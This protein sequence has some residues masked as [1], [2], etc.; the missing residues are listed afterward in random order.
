LIA[1]EKTAKK[2]SRLTTRKHE[3]LIEILNNELRSN[4]SGKT[5]KGSRT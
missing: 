5:M 4:G 2:Y 1:F 3:L